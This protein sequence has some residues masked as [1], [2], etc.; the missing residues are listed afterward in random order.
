MKYVA[1]VLLGIVISFAPQTARADDLPDSQTLRSRSDAAYGP[2]PDAYRETVDFRGTAASGTRV[3][4]RRGADRRV[5]VDAGSTHTEYGTYKGDRWHENV[6]GH[7]VYDQADPGLATREA[8][9]TTV[10]RVRTPIDAY[11]IATLN[12]KGDGT[13]DF[14]DPTSYFVVRRE[15]IAPN[16]KTVTV[17]D[18]FKAFGTRHLAAHWSI[19]DETNATDTDDTVR[20]YSAGDV[21]DS[22]VATPNNR[23]LLVEYPAGQ[24]R[25]VLPSTFEPS[26][27]ALVRLTIAGRGLDFILDTGA[28]SITI[29]PGVAASLGLTI[30]NKQQSSVNAGR[31]ATG[32]AVVPLIGV[33]TLMMHDVA[34]QVVPLSWEE[35]GARDVGLLGFDF[36]CESGITIDYEHQTVTAERYGSYTAPTDPRTIA[37]DA[38]LGTQQPMTTVSVNGAIAERV[39]VDT[40][41]A[42]P[43]LL[44]DYFKRRHPEAIPRNSI[45][46]PRQLGGAGGAFAANP[47]IVDDLTLANVHF[48]QFRGFE[49]ASGSSY[50]TDEDGVIG[51]TFLRFFDVHLD[52]PNGKIYLVP[53]ATGL[54]SMH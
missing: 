42:G 24:N 41:G 12:A 19:H 36:L 28:S 53:N 40:G 27:H 43:F 9:T 49:A 23:R 14:L 51:P 50:A 38:R 2:V 18:N 21:A 48:R 29:D 54:R 44:F 4:Y 22:D 26:G 46:P 16:G 33:G 45:G 31:F 35:P 25:V 7:V 30:T 3:T 20:D 8:I 15:T 1:Y 52:Y 34:V 11:V 10:T 32:Q 17:Y 6:N 37:L 39:I 13:R 47:V 5:V